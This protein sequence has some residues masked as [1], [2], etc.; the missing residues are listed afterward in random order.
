M[1]TEIIKLRDNEID[2]VKIKYA[3]EVIRNGGLVAFPTETVY[4]LGA[5]A[6][7]EAAV[8]KIFIAKG[9][10]NDNPLIVHISDK[11]EISNIVMYIPPIAITL[12]E[13]FWP[14][15]LTIIMNKLPIISPVVTAGL[16]TVAVRMPAHPVALTLIR[17]A[18][19]PIA[20]PSAN[21]SGRPSPTV[22]KHVIEDLFG[23]VD[24]IIDAGSARE[25]LE[26]TVLDLTIEPP[27][28]LRPGCVTLKQINEILRGVLLDSTQASIGE[29]IK[30][31]APGMKYAHYSPKADM[32]V[33]RGE[34]DRVIEKIKL[35]TNKNEVEGK[36]VG[37]LAT[38]QTKH[39]YH[40]A[41]VLSLGDRDDPAT[42][43]ANLFYELREFD[44]RNVQLIFAEAVEEN[45]IGL[46][47][48]NRMNKAAGFRVIDV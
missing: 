47:I 26:S 13:K 36:I 14:G 8:K 24:V 28:I 25:G 33:V 15:P 6:F 35:L 2:L 19:V 44:E 30:P 23:R 32:I 16:G 38:K 4:G 21:V 1:K 27:A 22:A 37:V 34:L 40:N 9:R 12:F 11:K 46:A 17:E 43:A 5:N 18:G 39:N 20:A 7:D 45:G 42:I 29:Y 31:R 41:I 3:A 10:P 48:M